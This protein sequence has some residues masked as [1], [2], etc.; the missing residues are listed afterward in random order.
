MVTDIPLEQIFPYI[1]PNA[2]FRGQWGFKQGKLTP[3]QFE[4]LTEEKVRPVFKELQRRRHRGK[5]SAAESRVRL[6]PARSN[7]N[8][9]IVYDPK[10]LTKANCGCGA[11]HG[12][13]IDSSCKLPE[14]LRFNFPRQEGRRRLCIADFFRST[15][16]GEYDVLGVQLVTV[17]PRATELAEQLR[18][19][20]VT[21]TIC[22]CTA[23]PSNRRTLAEFWHK[24]NAPG[25]WHLL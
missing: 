1:N 12:L 14:L 9:V 7:G 16:S 5:H 6:L 11:N 19:Q 25:T 15:E 23:S 22:I 24:R 17:G 10:E 2:L 20:T 8:D 18:L 4:K 21:R 13:K 3:E